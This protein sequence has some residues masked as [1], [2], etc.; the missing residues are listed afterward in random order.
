MP[1]DARSPPSVMVAEGPPSTPSPRPAREKRG[2]RPAGLSSNPR[3]RSDIQRIEEVFY[4]KRRFAPPSTSPRVSTT[5]DENA[6]AAGP[7]SPGFTDGLRVFVTSWCESWQPTASV[8]SGTGAAVR[9]AVRLPSGPVLFNHEVTKT[10]RHE[11]PSGRPGIAARAGD[12]GEIQFDQ[13]CET[14][15]AGSRE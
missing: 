1:F 7:A 8:P 5:M 10:R 15:L 2:R 12:A 9:A 11:G 3:R 6:A 4:S 13:S 14:A